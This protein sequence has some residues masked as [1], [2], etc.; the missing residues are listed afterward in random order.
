MRIAILV[1]LTLAATLFFTVAA[2]GQQDEVFVHLPAEPVQVTPP[3]TLFGAASTN[4]FAT[5]DALYRSDPQPAYAEL[6]RIWSWSMEDPVGAFYGVEGQE[7]LARMYPGFEAYIA[8]Y[9]LVDSR[10]N[11]YYPTV[12]TRRYLL[13]RAAEGVLA[14]NAPATPKRMPV[15]VREKAPAPA[16]VVMAVHVVSEPVVAAEPVIAPEP[17]VV[18]QPVAV[19]A[20]EAAILSPLPVA[21]LA[22][23]VRESVRGTVR[24]NEA[25]RGALSR[26]LFLM[27]AG[28]LGVGTLTVMMHTPRDEHDATPTH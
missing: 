22:S 14:Q 10:G 28:L 13:G 24:R 21:S 27:I 8:D 18:P 26:S 7:R 25:D 12:E 6:H 2:V 4:D 1:T 3:P 9:S 16:P 5:F 20:V 19:R 15:A 23:P 11:V 17:V